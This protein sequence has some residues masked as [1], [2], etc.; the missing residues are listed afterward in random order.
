MNFLEIFNEI[1]K[2]VLPI[3]EKYRNNNYLMKIRL[4]EDK[5]FL[6][7]ADIEIQNK[8][9]SIIRKYDSNASIIAEENELNI[10]NYSKVWII[11][12]IDGTSQFIDADK[13][14]FCTSICFCKNGIPSDSLIIMP[15]LG[16]NKSPLIAIGLL[17]EKKIYINYKVI[18]FN[19]EHIYKNVSMTRS[20]GTLPS[21]IEQE[22]INNGYEVKSRTTSQSIDL[23]RTAIDISNYT[24]NKLRPFYAFYRQNQKI[25]DGAPGICFNLIVGNKI[26]NSN[27][28]NLIPINYSNLANNGFIN[29]SVLVLNK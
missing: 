14:E 2:N 27:E 16:I 29:E 3:F 22:F 10:K 20:K 1:S 28:T 6:S 21:K 23:L 15:E 9:C 4:K 8:I 24:E 11:D 18:V 26:T 13:Y 25:W 5:T 7:D 12:P 19:K 17:D